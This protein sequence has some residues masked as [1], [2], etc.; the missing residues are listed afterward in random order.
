[1]RVWIGAMLAFLA[2]ACSPLSAFNTAVPK[3]PAAGRIVTGVP[4]GPDERQKLDVYPGAGPSGAKPVMVFIYGGS[5]DSGRRQDYSWVGRALASQGY[6]TI[7]P[8]YRLVPGNVFPDFLDDC[9]R[10]VRWARDHA[11]EHG[12]APDRIVLIGHSAGAYNAM[13][14]GLDQRYLDQAG[15]PQSAI[16][17]VVGLAGPYDFYPW[18]TPVSENAFG[19]FPDPAKTQPVSYARADAPP[20]LLLHGE[21]DTTVR[22]RNVERLAARIRAAGGQVETKLYPGMDHKGIVLSLSR[23][24]RKKN[25]VTADIFAFANRVTA[26]ASAPMQSAAPSP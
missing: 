21:A 18:D 7:V 1:M 26:P 19:R 5:W 4:F 10:A 11:A 15:V 17:G 16:R 12:G 2:A 9:A 13:M 3:D 24:Y 20:V 8:D 22:P 14:L 23:L 6:L 25:T